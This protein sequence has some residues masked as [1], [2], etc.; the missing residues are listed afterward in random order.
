M[1]V[2]NQCQTKWTFGQT[3][4]KMFTLNTSMTCP[5]C[6]ESQYPTA[7]T[8]KKN[9]LI[10][11]ILPITFILKLIFSLSPVTTLVIL[12]ST[13]II[14]VSTYPFWLELSNEEEALF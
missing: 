5:S 11:L 2:C 9:T 12:I 8:R 6:G 13:L 7:K 10:L 14:A 4:R 3:C 1:P